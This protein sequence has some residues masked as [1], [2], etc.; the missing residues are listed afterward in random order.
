MRWVAAV[1]LLIALW[2]LPAAAWAGQACSERAPARE[3]VQRALALDPG[4]AQHA[5]RLRQPM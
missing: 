4:L 3:M 5:V 2:W 1:E